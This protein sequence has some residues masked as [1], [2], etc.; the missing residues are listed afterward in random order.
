MR[1]AA[2]AIAGIV[3]V[4]RDGNFI[5]VVAETETAAE[6]GLAALRKGAV[7][8]PGEA[9]P[10]ETNLAAWLKSQPAETTTVDERK[11]AD[12]RASRPHHPP[13]V[14]APLHRPR[15]D[16]TILR[17]R[18]VGRRRQGAGLVA[19]PGRLR[20]AHRPVA[21]AG[22]AARRTSSCSTS[23]APAA[24]AT[25]AP[26]MWPSTRCCWRAQRPGAPC[27]CNGRARTSSPGRRWARRWPWRSRP[28]STR[29]ARSSCWRG[30][31]W[32]NGHVSRAGRAPIPTVLAASQ[33]AKPFE[34]FIA[35]NPPM[36]NGGG[37]R[38]QFGSALRPARVQ[39]HLPPAAHHADPHLGAAHAGRLRQRLRHRV[40]HGRAGGRARRGP[41][42]VSSA[43][44]EGSARP[45]RARG[46]GQAR[47]M[48]PRGPSAKVSATA[49]ASAATR[50]SAPTAPWWR[51]SRAPPTS[52]CAAWWLRSTSAR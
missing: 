28:I 41:A 21:G 1:S 20:P 25:T 9:L 30:E 42:G 43:A 49:S 13:A 51:R 46:R 5:G 16:G 35:F 7:W 22:A 52:A 18:A 38:A 39:G 31:V 34:R 40:L 45:C 11:A 12:T 3:A 27:A 33:L 47:R 8:G 2:R 36:A 29:A 15:V 48:E 26:T 37:R 17:D 50:I 23:K 4:V 19:L 10:D 6:A 14:L 32:S 44:S 24:T